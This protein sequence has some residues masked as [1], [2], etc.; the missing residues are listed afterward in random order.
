ML[1]SEAQTGLVD[2][3]W[4][5]KIK[6]IKIWLK[7]PKFWE[8]LCWEANLDMIPACTVDTPGTTVTQGTAGTLGNA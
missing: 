3:A 6:K 5:K 2:I 7:T 4:P 8:S 1:A